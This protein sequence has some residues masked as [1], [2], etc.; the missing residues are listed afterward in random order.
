MQVDY[1]PG[2]SNGNRGDVQ[3]DVQDGEDREDD[4]DVV[5]GRSDISARHEG[6]LHGPGSTV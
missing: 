6:A 5:Q 2:T 3:D 1:I 4:S